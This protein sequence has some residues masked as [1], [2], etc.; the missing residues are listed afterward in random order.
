MVKFSLIPNFFKNL[1]CGLGVLFVLF[2]MWSGV[3]VKA[4]NV[5]LTSEGI[6]C[7]VG[8]SSGNIGKCTKGTE[9]IRGNLMCATY[10]TASVDVKLSCKLGA[11][12]F[13]DESTGATFWQGDDVYIFKDS[14][15]KA[16][17]VNASVVKDSCNG[18]GIARLHPVIMIIQGQ[19][20]F[21]QNLLGSE[22]NCSGRNTFEEFKNSLK[23]SGVTADIVSGVEG[24]AVVVQ[25]PI[26]P[27]VCK[28]ATAAEIT[29]WGKAVADGDKLQNC[30]GKLVLLKADKTFEDKAGG[31]YDLNGKPNTGGAGTTQG[32][33]SIGGRLAN[34]GIETA[35]KGLGAIINIIL[36]IVSV[37]V[38]IIAYIAGWLLITGIWMLGYLFIIVLRIN[39]A[40]A[41]FVNVAADP[42]RI[43]VGVANMLVLS[44]FIFVGFGYILDI[45]KLKVKLEQF[46]LNIIVFTVVLNFTL[47]GSASIVNVTQGLGEI[48]I[49][50]YAVSESD[51]KRAN[52]ALINGLV[53]GIAR[54]SVIRCGNIEA[55]SGNPPTPTPSTTAVTALQTGASQIA[56]TNTKCDY[57]ATFTGIGDQ[58]GN[59]F[60]SLD[61]RQILGETL[62][63][64]GRNGS[65]ITITAMEIAFCVI[66]WM[67]IT[68]FWQATML[69]IMRIIGLWILIVLSPLALAAYISPIQGLKQYATKWVD[70]FWKWV[71][72]YPAFIFGLILVNIMARSFG[73]AANAGI[74]N[75]K[76]SNSGVNVFAD[77]G[78]IAGGQDG[79]TILMG[80]FLAIV[81]IL[82][83]KGMVSW[84]EKQFAE[85]AKMALGAVKTGWNML[86]TGA[87]V[88]GGGAA[89]LGVNTGKLGDKVSNMKIGKWEVG[90]DLTNYAKHRIK[91]SKLG[92]I[93]VTEKAITKKTAEIA[94][95]TAAGDTAKAARLTKEKTALEAKKKRLEDKME[96]TKGG[97][98][99]NVL[100]N[101]LKGGGSWF[102]AAPIALQSYYED[103]K[104]RVWDKS[105]LN[106]KANQAGIKKEIELN[107]ELD[108][109]AKAKTQAEADEIDKN[110]NTREFKGLYGEDVTKN[111]KYYNGQVKAAVSQ[112]KQAVYGTDKSKPKRKPTL[113]KIDYILKNF[114][115]D[116][117]KWPPGLRESYTQAVN[118]IVIM[119]A[120][121]SEIYN[122]WLGNEK[123]KA[124]TRQ[125]YDNISQEVGGDDALEKLK[126]STP[127][128]LPSTQSQIDEG[129]RIG[130]EILANPNSFKVPVNIT[131]PEVLKGIASVLSKEEMQK[132]FGDKLHTG[133]SLSYANK[134]VSRMVKEAGSA[135]SS[136]AITDPSDE[137]T[138]EALDGITGQVG[139]TNDKQIKSSIAARTKQVAL[140]S[141]LEADKEAQYAIIKEEERKSGYIREFGTDKITAAEFEV[142]VREI[143]TK[144]WDDATDALG[145]VILGIKNT[146]LAGKYK[147]NNPEVA[148][149]LASSDP[150]EQAKGQTLVRR[151]LVNALKSNTV[152]Q[153]IVSQAQTNF[154]GLLGA[155][156]ANGQTASNAQ[157]LAIEQLRKATAV[158]STPEQLRQIFEEDEN[159][160][161]RD[162]LGN[163]KVSED[164][165]F[166]QNQNQSIDS[167]Y[168][169]KS[170]YFL[171]LSAGDGAK[172]FSQL[173]QAITESANNG[174]EETSPGSGDY[175]FVSATPELSTLV[176]GGVITDMNALA[177][178][179]ATQG[180]SRLNDIRIAKDTSLAVQNQISTSKD[181]IRSIVKGAVSDANKVDADFIT[182][183]NID[184][185]DQVSLDPS[186][187]VRNV[188]VPVAPTP[189]T[190]PSYNTIEKFN[191][192]IINR[193]GQNVE[194]VGYRVYDNGGNIIDVFDN[195]S[196]LVGAGYPKQT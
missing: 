49:G 55:A 137:L 71:M 10:K 136:L 117:S 159:D 91:T 17:P 41:D 135:L 170:D 110:P 27:K 38:L 111:R 143:A 13:K 15:G 34:S 92:G 145:N 12:T 76:A 155:G 82:T 59:L 131:S 3:D 154:G 50:A 144:S 52:F 90:K 44:T 163:A 25:K 30:D 42:W 112:A 93:D 6:T 4:Q 133:N 75:L 146:A 160:V 196:D 183:G 8:V 120:S 148:R 175:R 57:G 173:N 43:V 79:L 182:K 164:I 84:F 61:P 7:E 5:S 140:S 192:P 73:S 70:Y 33:G 83:F 122:A 156:Y 18:F 102:A 116:I 169:I 188:N 96:S 194:L 139:F 23:R 152:R 149:L 128:I 101:A 98:G 107:R 78:E 29:S 180:N 46:F 51:P 181:S 28:D 37:F 150:D 166:A 190:T 193:S 127:D 99:L 168:G 130:N 39:P 2:G 80:A 162:T 179:I 72:F 97:L 151:A 161:Y 134:E 132:R 171:N 195:E 123:G 62:T 187:T 178:K 106:I 184:L 74:Q 69:A 157:L 14:S 26:D 35:M 142:G 126:L 45:A 24:I 89:A 66:A 16:I 167:D 119:S 81:V 114:D 53:D 11:L 36:L 48:M 22:F 40:G 147:K 115:E 174:I 9:E 158:A 86:K 63:I 129:K 124:I 65:L 32:D 77:F 85:L 64:N 141:L 189:P 94:T 68:A 95:A 186:L 165:R 105:S 121:D 60:T 58:A 1:I 125:L 109:R 87:G 172:K 177:K 31:K 47:L 54:A 176:T 67:A 113:D 118:D 104:F 100:G 20:N 191:R 153:D 138:L 19:M 21:Y 185:Y 56:N 88:V 108:R 103:T